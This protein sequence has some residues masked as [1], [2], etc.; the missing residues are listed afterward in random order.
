MPGAPA[1]VTGPPEPAGRHVGRDP[2]TVTWDRAMV[3]GRQVRYAVTGDGPAAL[4]LHGWGLRPNAYREPIR[5]MGAAG[6]R[7]YAPA[8]PGF[9]S[10]PERPGEQRSFTGY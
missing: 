8:M 9:G 6:C 10:T 7:V 1:A 5:H 3:D 4:F 2:N